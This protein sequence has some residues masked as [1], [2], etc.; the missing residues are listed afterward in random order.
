[1]PSFH[2][3]N[4]GEGTRKASPSLPLS[5]Y[6]TAPSSTRSKGMLELSGAE[7]HPDLNASTGSSGCLATSV[8]RRTSVGL[9]G[10]PRGHPEARAR[11]LRTAPRRQS[12]LSSACLL[13]LQ[14][15]ARVHLLGRWGRRR[16]RPSPSCREGEGFGG[17]AAPPGGGLFDFKS[18]PCH[19]ILGSP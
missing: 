2:A 15:V 14:D 7:T 9:E 19:F 1:M 4:P 13:C 3:K 16:A 6:G 10:T 8:Y 18:L 11:F 17:L 5:V 12:C